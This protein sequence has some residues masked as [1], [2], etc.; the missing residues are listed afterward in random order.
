ML[1]LDKSYNTLLAERSNRRFRLL[2][3]GTTIGLLGFVGFA[4]S[5]FMK[6]DIY[7]YAKT[8]IKELGPISV[9]RREDSQRHN[10]TNKTYTADNSATS[11]QD[12]GTI[13]NNTQDS[14][15]ESSDAPQAN[16]GDQ[17]SD[18][19]Q[20]T[21]DTSNPGNPGQGEDNGSTGSDPSP[22]TITS[23]ECKT[24]SVWQN[25]EACGWPG[26]S[27]TGP[28]GNL[29]LYP[30]GLTINSSGTYSNLD[31]RGYININAS[32]VTLRNFKLTNVNYSYTALRVDPGVT[33]IVLED[34]EINPNFV[35]Q[36]AIWGYDGITVRRCE[37]YKNGGA[38]QARQNV[39]FEE[40]YCHD[41]DDVANDGD[42][43]HTNCVIAVN[44]SRGV[45]NWRIYHNS[46]RLGT[47][48]GL[49]YLSGVINTLLAANNTIENNLIA[50]GAFSMY[51]FDT[52][53]ANVTPTNTVVKN[54]RF[55]IVDSPHVGIYGIWY[56]GQGWSSY[57]QHV[58]FSGNLVLETGVE[59]NG[60]EP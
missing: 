22:P 20:N 16:S 39:V 55:S 60:T 10:P 32:N 11:D 14:T 50:N 27:N 1:S 36:F 28:S 23:A 25:L 19:N 37:I 54:N 8:S 47:P 46:M 33:N 40:N 2:L 35:T 13:A 43:W 17:T 15:G 52:R 6:L 30:N 3:V 5:L 59:V 4:V 24:S 51:L 57:S 49:K 21:S 45:S 29:T 38:I 44:D 18:N 58:S 42:D 56:P 12:S 31:V 53:S 48:G 34:C 41:I 7:E 9:I 26:P